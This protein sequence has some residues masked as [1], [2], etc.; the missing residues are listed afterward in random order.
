MKHIGVES[1][2][3]TD[4]NPALH[5]DQ[6]KALNRRII[7]EHLND[8]Y[9][10][11][12]VSPES[13]AKPGVTKLM[14][15]AGW[16]FVFLGVENIHQK[17]LNGIRKKSNEDLTSRAI[18]NLYDD[19][20]T[21]LAGLI[22]G[23][24]NDTEEIIRMNF[25]WFKKHP[26]DSV[27]PQYL[28]PYP[29]TV[30]RKELLEEGLVMNKGGM[31]NEYGGWSTYNGEFAHCRT[32]GGLTLKELEAIVY[33]EYCDFCK[34]RFKKLVNGTL[35][36]AHN[37]PKHMCK[38]VIREP[39]PIIARACKYI[40]LSVSDRAEQERKRKMKMNQFNI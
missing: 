35:V 10:S 27:M 22:V 7:S 4:D 8:I 3:F 29:G 5:T 13:M 23:N 30:I 40:G 11:G 12:M 19:G 25:E 39:F 15:E 16:D 9:F 28:T 18:D 26:V 37:N 1:V 14:K 32:R 34:Y 38:W 31:N 36:F 33:E 24:P 17:N 20:I 2:F 6:F 21:T